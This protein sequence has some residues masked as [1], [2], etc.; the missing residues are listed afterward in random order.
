MSLFLRFF[1]FLWL[2]AALLAGSFLRSDVSRAPRP[3][4]MHSRCSTREQKPYQA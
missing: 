4:N 3:L 1:L 2:M